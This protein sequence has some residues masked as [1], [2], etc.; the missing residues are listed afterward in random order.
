MRSSSSY[1]S[2]MKILLDCRL[3]MMLFVASVALVDGIHAQI[4]A[5]ATRL[6]VW[7]APEK[8]ILSPQFS[9]DGNFVVLVTRAYWP[10]GADAEGLP[11]SFFKR[12]EAHAKADPRFAD[13]VIELISLAGKVGCEA[14]YG[15]N[16]SVS[17]DDE[18]VVFSEQVKPITGFRELASQAMV[19]ECMTAGHTN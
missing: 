11:D 4:Q 12:L 3:V 2:R 15:W 9:P 10:D 7:S 8:E 13:P 17:R 5:P 18:R 14:R 1:D 19:F 6:L 16:P